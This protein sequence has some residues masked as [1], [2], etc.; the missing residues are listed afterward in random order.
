MAKLNIIDYG[1]SSRSVEEKRE[2]L[3]NLDYQLKYIHEHDGYI[4]NMDPRNIYID[5]DNHFPFFEDIYSISKSG[6]EDPNEIKIVNLLWLADLA[7]CLYLPEYH[8]ENGLFSLDILSNNFEQLKTYFP[9]KDVN[10]YRGVFS[11]INTISYF[12]DYFQKID[13]SNSKVAA[14]AIQYIKSTPA[15]R[16]MALKDEESGLVNY[17]FITC[18]VFAIVIL[19]LGFCFYFLKV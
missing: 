12:S 7:F 8:L 19:V 3:Y 6:F 16:A 15:G 14:N 9:D 10:Y 17:V 2:F 5:D 13:N 4:R 11:N 18:V 1:I